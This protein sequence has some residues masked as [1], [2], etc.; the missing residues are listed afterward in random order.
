MSISVSGN[1]FV[2]AS[3]KTVQLRGVNVSGLESGVIFTGGT[4]FWQSSGFSSRPDF[5]KI[6]AWKANIVRLPMNEDSWLG[7]TVT[8]VPGNTIVLNGPAYQAEVEAT[9]KAANAAGLYVIL[10]LH[11]TAPATFAANYQNPFLNADNSLN[12]WKS[13]ATEFKGNQ[14]VMFEV[15][16]EP[17]VCAYSP[18]NSRCSAPANVNANQAL[19]QGGTENYYLGLTAGTYSTSGASTQVPYVYNTPSYQDAINTIRATGATNVIICGGNYYDD[20][21]GWWVQYPPTDPLNK[22]AAA[23][24]QYPDD[25][26]NILNNLTTMNNMIDPVAAN[27]PVIMTEMGDE[28]GTTAPP[29][30]PTVLAWLDLHGYSVTA[31]TWNPWGGANTLI[32]NA[33]TYTPTVGLGQT[34]YT[35]IFNHP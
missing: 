8:G 2:D 24:H 33:T 20:D 9:V 13:V 14:M 29:F 34:Y 22:L 6:A 15:F 27:H 5:T 35:W 26:P 16:N 1:H 18:G 31:W 19:A 25:V 23:V 3:G 12:F 32:Q 28:V 17:F 10:D 11:W 7:L 4:D 21:L 30:A